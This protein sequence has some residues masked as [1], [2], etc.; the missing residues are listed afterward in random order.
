MYADVAGRPHS[1]ALRPAQ[2]AYRSMPGTPLGMEPQGANA[3][4]LAAAMNHARM[5]LDGQDYFLGAQRFP[6][7]IMRSR[8]PMPPGMGNDWN[9]ENAQMNRSM[10]N[11]LPY[12][13]RDR[14]RDLEDQTRKDNRV[15]A[16]LNG[17]ILAPA[18]FAQVHPLRCDD[19]TYPADFQFPKT[20]EAMKILDNSQ[21]DRIMQAYRLPLDLQSI[22][23][24][25]RY[26]RD[27]TSSSRVRQAKL[28]NLWEFLGAYQLLEF[29]KTL[30]RIQY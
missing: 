18:K 2:D 28:Y 27:T 30:K 4:D 15:A 29:E 17:A 10:G 9:H 25:G 5:G 8:P 1:L 19:G 12:Q 16:L 13:E 22:S 3:V 6:P 14:E 11:M 20:V 23:S 21:L 26:A 7:G 24:S